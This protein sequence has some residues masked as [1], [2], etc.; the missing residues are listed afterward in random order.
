[1]I[2]G[3]APSISIQITT[4]PTNGGLVDQAT[5]T[6]S[7]ADLDTANNTASVSDNVFDSADLSITT[8]ETPNPV[9]IGTNFAYTLSIGN[10]GPTPA[11]AVEVDD[12]LPSGATFVSASGTGWTCSNSG[13]DVTCTLAS[14]NANSSASAITIVATAPATAQTM[15][16]TA[17]VSSATS[18]PD[19]T[20]NTATTS[21]LANLFADL[22][23]TLTDSPDPVQGTTNTG[24]S[25]NDCV[26]YT[27]PVAN[28]GPDTATGVKV[29][30]QLPGNGTF[31]NAV[32]S[33]WVCP[34]PS[35]TITCTRAASL[36]SGAT[37]PNITLVWKA[38]SPG[39]FSIVVSPTV[40]GTSTDPN[41]AN[42]TATEDTTVR[43]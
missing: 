38:P 18:D 2:V 8:D 36:A 34:A 5:V 14:L 16:N 12:T 33:G 4:P 13:N 40:S 19:T 20:N 43:P 23:V 30:I 17:T 22:S 42:N 28:A 29:V 26:T 31:F 32:G 7:T 3:A 11:T 25:S 41:T 9:R 24:C 15:S 1:L 37:A 6:A 21:T 35:T 27:I 10:D 39:G